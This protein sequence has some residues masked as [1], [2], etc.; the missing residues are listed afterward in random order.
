MAVFEPGGANVVTAQPLGEIVLRPGREAVFSGILELWRYRELAWTLTLRDISVRYKQSLLGFA[1]VILQP[2]LTVLIF[3]I[4]FGRLAKLPTENNIPYPIFSLTGLLL[5]NFY[6]TAATRASLSIVSNFNLV[7]KVYFPRMI[8]PISAALVPVADFLVS[9]LLLIAVGL[10]YHPDIQLHVL[11]GPVFFL[12]AF[13]QVL[14]CSLWLAALHV[15]FRDVQYLLPFL[16]QVLMY[17]CP[18]CYSSTIIPQNWIPFYYLNPVAVTIDGFRWAI[19][20]TS[21][22]PVY[23]LTWLTISS[24]ILLTTGFYFFTS[25]EGH[26]SDKI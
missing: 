5:W 4:L 22:P 7:T 3:S 25:E 12:L 10:K 14:G 13:F 1:W 26:F 16:V 8:V 11:L 6:S 15:R 18:I 24:L 21:L 2:A 19:L 20:S 17:A 23:A 9:L